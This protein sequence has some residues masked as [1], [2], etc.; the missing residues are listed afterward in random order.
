[1]GV[2]GKMRKALG[3]RN[4][5]ESMEQDFNLD[6]DGSGL[7]MMEFEAPKDPDGDQQMDVPGGEKGG[8]LSDG[9]RVD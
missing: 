5:E 8:N 3:L 7:G 4:D 9:F 1:M 2:G 6:G